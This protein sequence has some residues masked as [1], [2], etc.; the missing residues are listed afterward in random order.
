MKRS[1]LHLVQGIYNSLVVS[2]P[3]G[4][5]LTWAP[6]APVFTFINKDLNSGDSAL[7]KILPDTSSNRQL[8]QE[9][10]S[11]QS[12]ISRQSHLLSAR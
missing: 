11:Q 2:F 4:T 12:D 9:R 6:P 1:T 10:I 8:K 3:L 5:S 7:G